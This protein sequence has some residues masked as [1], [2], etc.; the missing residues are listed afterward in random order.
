MP[1]MVS[2]I[3][4]VPAPVVGT[5]VAIVTVTGPVISV[6]IIVGVRTIIDRTGDA[7]AKTKADVGL[8]F[9]LGDKRQSTNSSQ[10]K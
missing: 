5:V 7:K 8:R 9:W 4:I 6:W 1:P 10:K 2:V 3:A